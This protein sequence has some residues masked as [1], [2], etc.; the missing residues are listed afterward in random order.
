ME[1]LSEMRRE[2]DALRLEVER[3]KKDVAWMTR[4]AEHASVPRAVA[5]AF[6]QYV[7]SPLQ[8]RDVTKEKALT[9]MRFAHFAYRDGRMPHD[10][11]VKYEKMFD[12]LGV[13]SDQLRE[14][15]DV[16]NNMSSPWGCNTDDMTAADALRVVDD[17]VY[18]EID[19]D[20]HKEA[21]D[22]DSIN[23]VLR[24]MLRAVVAA[25]GGESGFMKLK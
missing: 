14:T 13:S 8:L 6:E 17:V 2:I 7:L 9:R 10:D 22:R 20:Y 15:T 4:E 21:I 19:A 16:V 1:Q 5:R 23:D 25:R 11:L 24:I 12:D 3:Q 18:T